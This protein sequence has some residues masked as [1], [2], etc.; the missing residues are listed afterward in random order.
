MWKYFAYLAFYQ[1]VVFFS[2]LVCVECFQLTVSGTSFQHFSCQYSNNHLL[3]H[4]D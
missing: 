2:G 4:L 1:V 3:G